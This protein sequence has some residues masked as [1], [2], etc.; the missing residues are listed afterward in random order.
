MKERE[1]SAYNA[2]SGVHGVV[3]LGLGSTDSGLRSLSG[4]GGQRV[5]R[6]SDNCRLCSSR[7]RVWDGLALEAHDGWVVV[8]QGEIIEA[9]GPAAR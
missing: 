8:V 7:A 9:A 4:E 2:A 3:S 1:R 6:Q 5:R